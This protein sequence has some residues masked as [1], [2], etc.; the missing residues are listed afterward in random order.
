MYIIGQ[1]T[2]S[3]MV[4]CGAAIR[5]LG[6]PALSAE[7]VSS[8]IAGYLYEN[9]GNPATGE[10]SCVLS[11]VYATLPYSELPPDVQAFARGGSDSG[12]LNESTKCLTLLG[13]RGDLEAWNSRHTS[14]NHQAIPLRSEEAIQRLPMIAQ[15]V[16]QFGIATHELLH[17]TPELILD[18][19]QRNYNVFHVPD[20][21]GSPTI[22][23]QDTFV[24]PHGVQSVLGFGGVFPG[25][26]LFAVILFSRHP[27]SHAT[28][29]MFR[30]IT[31]SAKVALLPGFESGRVFDD[32]AS[33]AGAV[34]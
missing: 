15:L 12:A 33:T 24:V 21:V 1:L 8:A 7:R 4:L 28:A 14:V 13:T 26:G 32:M 29:D 23:A 11:R 18:L 20:A 25:G 10:R 31:L 6:S 9:L 5:K 27:I 19:E 16:H 3:D 30:T 22:P 17:P 2:L 34:R